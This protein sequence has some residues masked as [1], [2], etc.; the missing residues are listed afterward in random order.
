MIVL[1]CWGS[2]YFCLRRV[3]HSEK[4][5]DRDSLPVLDTSFSFAFHLSVALKCLQGSIFSKSNYGSLFVI[6]CGYLSI[7]SLKASFL[8]QI[9]RI[10]FDIQ[11]PHEWKKQNFFPVLSISFVTTEINT[12]LF[13]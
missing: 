7:K 6:V 5:N 12:M 2:V 10:L 8:S 4:K 11:S 13:V 3:A 9:V 1:Y